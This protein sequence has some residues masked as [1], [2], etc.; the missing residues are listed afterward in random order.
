MTW[1]PRGEVC[2]GIVKRTAKL[3]YEYEKKL[4]DYNVRFHGAEGRPD[5]RR[6]GQ[7]EVQPGPLVERLRGFGTLCEGQLVAGPW[8]DLPPQLNFPLKLCAEQRVAGNSRAEGQEAGSGVLGSDGGDQK[9]IQSHC[10]EGSG[11]VPIQEAGPPRTG[12]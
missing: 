5:G 12:G 3:T 7:E 11:H 1:Y 10:G 9:R 6:R 4:W 8:E 2:K